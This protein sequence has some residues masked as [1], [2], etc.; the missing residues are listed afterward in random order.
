MTTASEHPR[1]AR[2]GA[3]I[4]TARRAAGLSQGQLARLV[5]IEQSSVAQWERGATAP[6]LA[7]FRELA[8]RFGLRGLWLLEP[9]TVGLGAK[10]RRCA[11]T[12]GCRSR[13]WRNWSGS[14]PA[15]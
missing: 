2:L 1:R 5:G 11:S 13:R 7:H 15:R 8:H 4:R 12:T 9:S 14:R 6:S 10:I 3:W